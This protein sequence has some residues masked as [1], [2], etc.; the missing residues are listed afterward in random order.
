[1]QPSIWFINRELDWLFCAG[2]LLWI[3]VLL[4]ISLISFA[5]I[6]GVNQ[7]F[8]VTTVLGTH[9]FAEPHIAASLLKLRQQPRRD[10][11]IGM[12]LICG[13]IALVALCVPNSV[14]ILLYAYF[15]FVIPHYT[16]QAFG[17]IILYCNRSGRGITEAERRI[18]KTILTL[19]AATAI[20][21]QVIPYADIC[22]LQIF[23]A[24]QSLRVKRLPMPAAMIF[25]TTLILLLADTRLTNIMWLYAPIFFHSTQYLA[26]TAN[27]KPLDTT[28]TSYFNGLF[29]VAAAAFFVL[30][31]ALSMLGTQQREAFLI[32]ASM[33]GFHHFYT[34]SQIWKRPRVPPNAS[35]AT[36]CAAHSSGGRR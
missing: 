19:T 27:G 10:C 9:L 12:P 5:H 26:V 30:P 1:M 11:V 14:G 20:L 3:I 29:I 6:G 23:I 25:L 4:H 22:P 8:V 16:G 18:L 21:K 28:F 7:A 32:I 24:V 15:L 34:D 2:G 31:A 35:I 36:S 33:F 13:V 17:M